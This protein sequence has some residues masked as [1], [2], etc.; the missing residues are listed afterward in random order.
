[1]LRPTGLNEE[2]KMEAPDVYKTIGQ[3]IR[4]AREA[5]G[6]RQDQLAEAISLTRTSIT[7]IEQGKQRLLVHT[8]CDIA[9]ALRVEPVDL[10]PRLA[11]LMS[12]PEVYDRPSG[13]LTS[14]EWDWIQSVIT[15]PQRR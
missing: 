2:V 8:L 5:L 7:N 14:Q 13:D 4:R 1:M 12:S 15:T 9:A 3:R 10:L 11:D 6:L